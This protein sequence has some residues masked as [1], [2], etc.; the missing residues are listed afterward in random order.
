MYSAMGKKGPLATL[1]SDGTVKVKHIAP[2]WAV[3]L[4]D[5]DTAA[6]VNIMP[7]MEE[8]KWQH[9]LALTHG[10][11]QYGALFK[12]KLPFLTNKKDLAPGDL[13][14]LPYDGGMSEMLCDKFPPL[15]SQVS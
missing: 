13:L 1:N 15:H 14:V 6:L 11:P 5:R 4:A 2:Y 9:P 12:L 7:Y 10:Q 3:M 8:Y